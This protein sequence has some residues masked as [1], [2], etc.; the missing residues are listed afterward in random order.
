LYFYFLLFFFHYLVRLYFHF[1]FVSLF[2]ANLFF[3][4]SFS[5]L[6]SDTTKDSAP[7][8]DEVP[9]PVLQVDLTQE[10]SAP[11]PVLNE[12]DTFLDISKEDDVAKSVATSTDA[13]AASGV[14]LWSED[15]GL[16]SQDLSSDGTIF[17]QASTLQV[18]A[19]SDC[20]WPNPQRGKRTPVFSHLRLIIG[21]SGSPPSR[22][23]EMMPLIK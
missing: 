19:T 11:L 7:S 12:S 6:S 18:A 14:C 10:H 21:K 2:S 13:M 22:R 20:Q 8:K 23:R 3:F 9:E 17:E 5:T 4:V 16:S 1:Q 15:S